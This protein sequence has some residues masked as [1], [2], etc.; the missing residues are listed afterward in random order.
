MET[1][2]FGTR[3]TKKGTV[4]LIDRDYKDRENPYG[5]NNDMKNKKPSVRTSK[6]DKKETKKMKHPATKT[7]AGK[8]KKV[9]KVKVQRYEEV[10][11]AVS[12]KGLVFAPGEVCFWVHNGPAL[13]SLLD[14]RTAFEGMINENQYV[15][16]VNEEKNDFSQWVLN[17]L[18]DESCS[19]DLLKAK[20]MKAALK[21]VEK[22]LKEYDI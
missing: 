14:L 2:P 8:E 3:G 5:Y 20:E 15:Y 19:K 9:T 22:H 18:N 16:H 12:K 11:P 21:V 10:K 13:Q 7:S 1:I 17:V 4:N 6:S